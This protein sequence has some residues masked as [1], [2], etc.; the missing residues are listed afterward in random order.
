[1]LFRK[2]AMED[3]TTAE[4][5]RPE[6]HTAPK[7]TGGL[8][9]RN[10]A[11]AGGDPLADDLVR[12]VLQAIEGWV[13]D[14]HLESLPRHIAFQQALSVLNALDRSAFPRDRE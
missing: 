8:P 13:V 3:P 10:D 1:M 11:G 12:R 9:V 14:N 6:E 5:N 7:P 4:T 2:K